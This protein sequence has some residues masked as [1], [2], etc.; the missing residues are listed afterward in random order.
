MAGSIHARARGGSAF[1]PWFV[2]N[3][4]TDLQGLLQ[5][6]ALRA[7]GCEARYLRNRGCK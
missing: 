3:V 1:A 6:A 5:C 2:W 4:E 7:E